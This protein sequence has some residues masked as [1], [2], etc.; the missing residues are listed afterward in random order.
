MLPKIYNAT[1]N[2]RKSRS[3]LA[4]KELMLSMLI[5]NDKDDDELKAAKQKHKD[6]YQE[7]VDYLKSKI[8]KQEKRINKLSIPE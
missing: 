3:E 6:K 4:V 5:I 8:V 2:L 7:E 1:M